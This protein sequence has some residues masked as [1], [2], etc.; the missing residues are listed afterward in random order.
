MATGSFDSTIVIHDIRQRLSEIRRIDGLHRGVITRLLWN[1][2]NS[3]SNTLLDVTDERLINL[4]ST[5]Y[6]GERGEFG[7]WNLRDIIRGSCLP[8]DR[9]DNSPCLRPVFFDNLSH[10]GSIKAV[11]WNPHQQQLIATGG[12]TRHDPV[13]RLFDISKLSET[14]INNNN[15][16]LGS[17][18]DVVHSIQCNSPVNSLCWRKTYIEGQNSQQSKLSDDFG[19]Q[20]LVSTH[21]YPDFGIKLWQVDDYASNPSIT[22]DPRKAHGGKRIK[23]WFTKIR[24]WHDAHGGESIINSLLSPNS[25]ILSTVGADETI[26]FW[27]MFE[28]FNEL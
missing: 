13:I 25:A 3:S 18:D 17:H 21:G 1:C 6:N 9:L 26:R 2:N 8:S 20:E 12:L 14:T 10:L 22:S 7:V 4:A 5:A 27:K 16:A 23:Y 24:E 19:C 15:I 11:A 28:S